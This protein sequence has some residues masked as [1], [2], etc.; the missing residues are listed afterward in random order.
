MKRKRGPGRNPIPKHIKRAIVRD[1]RRGDLLMDVT[2]RYGVSFTTVLI[3]ARRAGVKPR[4]RGRKKA[5]VPNK[6]DQKVLAMLKK[7]R[8]SSYVA[9]KFG[10]SRQMV[11]SIKSRWPKYRPTAS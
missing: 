6:R 4:K 11:S 2:K 1:Y 8:S 7:G 9:E 3:A 10:V 5:E